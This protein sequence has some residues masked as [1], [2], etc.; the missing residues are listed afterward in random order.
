M[1]PADSSAAG[2]LEKKRN[3]SSGRR[4]SS[5][6]RSEKKLQVK[7]GF[8]L[9]CLPSYTLPSDGSG[10]HHMKRKKLF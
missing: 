5:Y 3:K 8:I 10:T 2:S 1:P 4:C 7:D 9:A 6:G